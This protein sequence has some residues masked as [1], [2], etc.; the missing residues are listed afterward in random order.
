MQI[1]YRT[2]NCN[3]INV[4]QTEPTFYS[5][6]FHIGLLDYMYPRTA[7]VMFHL[8]KNSVVFRSCQFTTKEE[9]LKT[10]PNPKSVLI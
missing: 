7:R 9:I 2:Y 1:F 6:A 4:G 3:F 10:L 5:K 8:H